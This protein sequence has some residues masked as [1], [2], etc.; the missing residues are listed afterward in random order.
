[1]VTPNRMQQCYVV[2]SAKAPW[3]RSASEGITFECQVL[4]SGEDG[5]PEAMRFR[6]DDCPSFQHK[7]ARRERGQD[8]DKG[9]Y[10]VHELFPSR[11]ERPL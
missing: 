5:G 2:D 11:G 1:M 9:R 7:N 3:K 8:G 4:L 10:T 6:F